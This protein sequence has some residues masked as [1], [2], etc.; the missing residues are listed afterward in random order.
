MLDE[1][2]DDDPLQSS[3][4]ASMSFK[5][6]R[7]YF[8]WVMREQGSFEW[9]RGVMDEVA[10]TDKKHVIEQSCTT[11]APACTKRATPT[12]P[13]SPCCSRCTTLRGK[14]GVDVVSGTRVKS[15]FA[16]PNWRNVYK[17][18]ALNH[19]DER[20]GCST[21]ELR[22]Y[23]GAKNSLNKT[24]SNFIGLPVKPV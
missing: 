24:G 8:Y 12:P 14:R 20:V 16:H 18:I 15:H 19:H 21:A 17:R 7:A 1:E 22:R 6:R 4:S 5:T 9:F 10:E 2:T 23:E 11:T 13:S 3:S